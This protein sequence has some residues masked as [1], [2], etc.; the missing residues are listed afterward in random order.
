MDCFKV[1]STGWYKHADLRQVS[2]ILHRVERRKP[3]QMAGRK[4][5]I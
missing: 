4:A 5:L 3:H 2:P 1:N